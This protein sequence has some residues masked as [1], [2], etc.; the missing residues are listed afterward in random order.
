[1]KINFFNIN[2]HLIYGFGMEF[3][4]CY[5]ELMPE[6]ALTSVTVSDAYRYFEGQA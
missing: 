1:M 6:G 5:I 3:T 2:L 4:S